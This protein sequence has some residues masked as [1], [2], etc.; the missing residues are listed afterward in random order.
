M[1]IH[2]LRRRADRSCSLANPSLASIPPNEPAE[3]FRGTDVRRVD[4]LRVVD[5]LFI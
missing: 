3:D 1:T 5:R 4:T 2:R